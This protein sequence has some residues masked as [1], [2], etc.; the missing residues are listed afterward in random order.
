[1]DNELSAGMKNF[2]RLA[3]SQHQ[4]VPTGL[5]RSLIAEWEIQIFKHYLI[6]GLSS[7]DPKLPLHLWLRLIRQALLTLNLLLLEKL[8][9]RLSAKDFLNIAFNLNQTPLAP[10]GTKVLIFEGTG[11]RRTFTQN[12]VEG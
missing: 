2:F 4:M 5:Y 12:G 8:N 1:M 11:D 3:G 10:P 6:S 7:C 9:P